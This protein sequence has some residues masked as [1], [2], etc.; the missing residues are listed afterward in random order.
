MMRH[1]TWPLLVGALALL[2]SANVSAAADAPS[3]PIRKSASWVSAPIV[4]DTVFVALG[5]LPQAP[6]WQ[7]GDPIREVP[8][9]FHGDIN[10]PT[11]VPANRPNE[12]DALARLQASVGAMRAPTAFGSPNVSVAGI[13]YT[14]V[15]PPDP[16]GDIGTTHY[17]QS[18]NGSS[19]ARYQ[20]YSKTGTVVAGPFSM[21]TLASG[22]PCSGGAGDPIVLFDE[23]A[24]RWVLTEFTAS[25]NALCFYISALADPTVAQTWTRYAFTAPDFPDYPKYGVW[26]DAYYVGTNEGGDVPMYAFD[27]VRMLAGQPMTVQRFTAPALAGFGFQVLQPADLDGGAP[28]VGAPGIFLRHRDDEAHAAGSNNP[29]RDD[30]EL[31]ELHIDWATPANSTLTGPIR[32]AVSEFSSDLNG[33]SAFN[34]FPQPSGQKL[35]P[36]REPVMF[37]AAYRSYGSFEQLV[38][39]WVTDIDGNDTGGVRWFELRRTGGIAEPWQLYQEGT[40][41]LGDFIDRWMGA[42]ATDKDGNIALAYSATRDTSHAAPN[43][44]GV[45]A[46]LRYIGRLD[47]DP[48]LV[49]TTGES[50]LNQPGS[51]SQSGQRWGDYHAMNVD[52]VDGCT[53]WFTG[54]AVS[55][56]NWATRIG[57]FSHTAC[58]AA[59][60]MLNSGD[61]RSSVCAVSDPV[62]V[63]IDTDVLSRNG[64]VGNV[65]LAFA[66]LPAGISGSFVPASVAAPGSSVGTLTVSPGVAA[67]GTHPITLIGTSGALT[68]EFLVNLEV[69]APPS[70]PTL[71]AP[72]DAAIVPA[73]PSLSWNAVSGASGYQLQVATDAAFTNIVYATTVPTTSHTVATALAGDTDHY[74]RVAASNSGCGTGA[75]SA[76][77]NFRTMPPPGACPA[78]QMTTILFSDPV[79]PADPKGWIATEIPSNGA[80][81]WATTTTRPASPTHAFEGDDAATSTEQRLESPAI[82]VPADSQGV[83]VTFSHAYDLEERGATECWDG[84]AVDF[85]S[86]G[87]SNFEPIANAAFSQGGY[88]RTIR[89]ATSGNVLSGR[90]AWCA[91]SLTHS[92]VVANLDAMAGNTMKLR[93]RLGTDSSQATDGW[94]VDDIV[95]KSCSSGASTST[96]LVSA[97]EPTV[98][99]QSVTLTATVSGG[100]TTPGGSVEFFDGAVSL[101]VAALNGGGVATLPVSSLSVANHALSAVYPGDATHLGSTGLDSHSVNKAATELTISAAPDPSTQGSLVTVTASLAVPLPGAGTPSGTVQIVASNS[102][103]CTIILPDL[104]C[105]LTFSASGSQTIDATYGGD[106]NFESDAAP[107]IAHQANANTAPTID[108]AASQIATLEDLASGT[109]ALT[110]ADSESPGALSVSATASTDLALMPLTNVALAGS[111]V[112]RTVSFSPTAN[113][114]GTATVTLEVSDPQGLTDQVDIEVT[115]APVND[116]P[117]FTILGGRIHASGSNGAQN[118][119]GFVESTQF[120]PFEGGQ[121]VQTYLIS[122]VGSPSGVISAI[123]LAND[124]TLSYTLTGTG[125]TATIAV[126]LQD[127]GGVANGGVDMSATQQFTIN[128]GDGGD[129]SVSVDDGQ[130]VVVDGTARSY[131]VLVANAGPN[132]AFDAA[133]SVPAASGGS[134]G[135]WTCAGSGATCPASAGTGPITTSIDLP[136]SASLTYQLEVTATAAV[137]NMMTVSAAIGAPPSFADPNPANNSD[138][139]ADSIVT[140]AL[141]ANSFED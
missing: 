48:A 64:F 118:V 26:P 78:G 80:V 95:V 134:I 5:D 93:F 123:A 92:T 2:C 89:A 87:G 3:A 52:P 122:E 114:F 45:S 79:D 106:G 128:V 140:D 100:A 66:S 103:G 109:V 4:P 110:L 7:P 1:P 20:I 15:Q 105:A 72:A 119:P 131:S 22:A 25:G 107:Q 13:G 126:Q 125:G 16:A 104:D 96:A 84:G 85:S 111:G 21:E 49:M 133:L 127:D 63:P 57:A 34:A 27:R 6:T 73:S 121:A 132:A 55:G 101:G 65:A 44:T 77:R 75:F 12:I 14:S 137:G 129:L 31:F 38:G 58:G 42:I 33:L 136:A 32:I 70:A 71:V 47:G 10:A 37:R 81:G 53:F 54:E 76:A 113:R 68:K 43:N 115:V 62:M 141:F 30:L 60:F 17:I 139:D 88:T 40:V 112:S 69:A 18:I 74:W 102:S 35:D 51:G 50:I 86:D 116:A 138:S 46:G 67:A 108:A 9:Q 11:P 124:G 130:L 41:A 29:N 39:N 8:R 97:P 56:S 36:L 61:L 19:G 120:G 99:G 91:S 82:V 23:L 28:P 117:N 94:Y 83:I 24:A 135:A 98:F 59:Q 90:S